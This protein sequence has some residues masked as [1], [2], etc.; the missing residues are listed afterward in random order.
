MNTYYNVEI[1]R[2]DSLVDW[3]TIRDKIKTEQQ[4]HEIV[5]SFRATD[6]KLSSKCIWVYRI[7]YVTVVPL[8][9]CLS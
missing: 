5:R 6:V 7:V 9:E 3:Y 1:K 2:K 4:A 8:C